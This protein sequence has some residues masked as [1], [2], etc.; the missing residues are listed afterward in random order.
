MKARRRVTI[1]ASIALLACMI[2]TVLMHRG[3]LQ[4]QEDQHNEM[5]PVLHQAAR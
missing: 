2:A 3:L 1:A 5:A 4:R